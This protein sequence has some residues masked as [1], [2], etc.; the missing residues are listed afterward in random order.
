NI[1]EGVRYR[2]RR[3]SLAFKEELG[4]IV[5]RLGAVALLADDGV[6]LEPDQDHL[7]VIIDAAAPGFPG[8]GGAVEDLGRCGGILQRTPGASRPVVEVS[9][10]IR[11]L[12]VRLLWRQLGAA[13]CA[14]R[15]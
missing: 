15:A 10:H 8:M 9:G 13:G 12:V 4:K 14:D 2:R 7:I 6:S 11:N 5:K 1:V 3:A